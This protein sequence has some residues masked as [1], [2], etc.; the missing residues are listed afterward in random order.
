M[1]KLSRNE[2]NVITQEVWSK[3]NDLKLKD[4]KEKSK[5]DKDC[6]N[7]IKLNK[8]KKLLNDKISSLNDEMKKITESLDKKYNNKYTF[9]V[10]NY[11]NEVGDLNIWIK[12]HSNDNLYNK[13]VLMGID[14]DYKV[15]D[16]I[17]DLV[18]EYSK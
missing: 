5:K 14:K 12:R 17:A 1:R 16:L 6:I 7:L 11:N 3:V 9:C 18:K 13:I 4:I 15:N 2:V 10:N 8:D